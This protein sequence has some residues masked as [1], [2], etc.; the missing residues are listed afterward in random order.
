LVVRIRGDQDKQKPWDPTPTPTPTPSQ[1][2]GPTSQ[3][4]GPGGQPWS[5][6]PDWNAPAP[7]GQSFDPTIGQQPAQTQKGSLWKRF[8][9]WL[10]SKTR[11]ATGGISLETERQVSG[12]EPEGTS[13]N[14]L[15]WEGA[16]YSTM[17]AFAGGTVAL[18]PGAASPKAWLYSKYSQAEQAIKNIN[19]VGKPTWREFTNIAKTAKVA[20][21]WTRFLYKTARGVPKSKWLTAGPHGP[22]KN[23]SNLGLMTNSMVKNTKIVMKGVLHP[24]TVISSIIISLWSRKETPEFLKFMTRDIRDEAEKSGDFSL[25]DDTMDDIENL[26]E[27]NFIQNIA[28]FLPI[29]GPT[30]EIGR[31]IKGMIL[32]VRADRQLADDIKLRMGGKT[33]DEIW[34]Q[35]ETEKIERNTRAHQNRLRRERIADIKICLLYTSPSPRD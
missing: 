22:F 23:I 32:A 16:K 9:D 11:Q 1:P 20:P 6:T 15:L 12:V 26:I 3:P 30:Q 18:S 10:G 35:R 7:T 31:A 21:K 25:Y 4:T 19:K 29:I 34:A 2:T 8:T 14:R 17:A 28:T 27:H 13:L 24:A 33:E 5:P